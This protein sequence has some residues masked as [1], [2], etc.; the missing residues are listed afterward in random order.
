M[1][2]HPSLSVLVAA[3]RAP[4][5]W[6]RDTLRR[7]RVPALGT[8]SH[9]AIM[10]GALVLVVLVGL[11]DFVSGYEMSFPLLYLA[12]ITLVT[13]WAGRRW[14]VA[15]ASFSTLVW[16]GA[17]MASGHTFTHP[18]IPFWNTLM[19]VSCFLIMVIL[20]AQLKRSYEEQRRI[21]HELRVSLTQ[22]K[23]LSGLIPMCAWCKKVRDDQ[24]YWQQVEAYIAEHSEATFTHG[25]C[26]ECHDKERQ[27]LL[28]P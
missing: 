18:L 23:I 8:Q 22:V 20:L 16:L 21:A 11:L 17:E 14:G 24:G 6:F 7:L 5:I 28:H 15:V 12:P 1:L 4:H 2:R 3:P 9:T 25:I 10:T 19:R 26:Q 27:A 13:W